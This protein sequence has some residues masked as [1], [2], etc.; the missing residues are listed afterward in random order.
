MAR[1]ETAKNDNNSRLVQIAATIV[2]IWALRYAQE[3]MVPIA[4]AVLFAFLLGPLVHRLERARMPRVPA[5][6]IVV[7]LAFSLIFGVGVLV[8]RQVHDLMQNVPQY[9]DQVEQQWLAHFKGHGSIFSRAS[10]AMHKLAQDVSTSQP[11]TP[12]NGAASRN[13]A[14]GQPLTDGQVSKVE[15]VPGTPP[16]LDMLYSTFGPVL[17]ALV[18]G[19]VVVVL[20]IF[21]L[22][23][24]EDL[25]DRV[26]RL[27]SHGNLN[28]TNQAM[29]DAAQRI[30]RYLL[31]QALL[32]GS[33][34]ICVAMGLSI[35]GVPNPLLWG[36]LSALLRFIP[37]VGA[38]IAAAIPILLAF[39]T[40]SLHHGLTTLGMYI[41][42]EVVIS[43]FIEPWLYG[44]RTGVSSMAI[45]IAAAF[46]A[47]V[48]GG[49]GLLLATPLTVLLV[50][51]GKYVPQLEFLSVLLGDEP[52]FDPAMRYYQRLLAADQ[53]E[54]WELIEEYHKEMSIDQVFQRV[55]I[56]ALALAHRDNFRGR[57]DNERAEYIHAA[58]KEQ[59]EDLAELPAQKPSAVAAN[60]SAVHFTPMSNSQVVAGGNR[61]PSDAALEYPPLPTIHID[62]AEQVNL[63]C[64]PARD[65]ADELAGVMFAQVLE[66]Q[67]FKVEAV[68]VTSLVGE[69]LDLVGQKKADIVIISA[70]P[71]SAIGHARYLCKRLNQKYP[72]VS[73]MI[74]LWT[75]R[76]DL[77]EAR[78]KISCSDGD[79][80]VNNFADGLKQIEQLMHPLL[81]S[82]PEAA[83]ITE[84]QSPKIE[85]VAKVQ[86]T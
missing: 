37:Y 45:L 61:Q 72:H 16:A 65:E 2:I 78:N 18:T 46:W 39:A 55:M 24:R 26:I 74:G 40:L 35:I 60:E 5:V 67:G 41:G 53:E 76:G 20:C 71:P 47:W 32:N 58:V 59:I 12:Q 54:A 33:Y 56:P 13:P 51:V 62:G 3:V 6:L 28:V 80:V 17:Q 68:S 84:T 64:L 44:S 42:L 49:V 29:D 83:D 9:A 34:G 14:T 86:K 85:A 66:Q 7:L 31:M 1:Q 50:V 8:E 27:V 81:L 63:L 22:L 75:S 43:S 15:V 73:L 38:W 19:F 79:V 52:V 30:S 69:M 48:W 70:L 11:S 4:L 82:K 23:G 10:A 77:S 21:M 36:L 25:R 57:L